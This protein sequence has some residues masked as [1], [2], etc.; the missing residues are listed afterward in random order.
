MKRTDDERIGILR[1]RCIDRKGMVSNAERPIRRKRMWQGITISAAKSLRASERVASWQIRC[2]LRTRDILAE[3]KFEIDDLELLAGRI[4]PQAASDSEFEDADA[5]VARY[6][7]T[8]GQSGHCELDLPTLFTLGVNGL[9]DRIDGLMADADDKRTE[10]YQSF[11][12]ALDGFSAMAE[13]AAATAEAGIASAPDWRKA[14]LR[15]IAESCRRIAH[16]PP[17]N[18]RDAVQLLW[19]AQLGAMLGDSAGLVVSGHIDRTLRP[20]YQADTAAGKISREQA[21]ILIESLYLLVNE[22]IADGLAMS[23]MVGGRDANGDDVTNDLSYLG[24]EALRRTKLIYPA[25]GVCWHEGTPSDL[26]DLAIELIGHGYSTPAFFGAETI[27]R[28]LKELGAA[29]EHACNYINSTCVEIT[30][31]A[32]SNVWVASPYFN[33]CGA[34]ME[35]IDAQ[36]DSGPVDNFEDFVAAYHRRM[37]DRIARAVAEQNNARRLRQ[38]F[39]G[40]PFQSVLTRDCIARGR[41]IDDG[42][43]IYNWVECSFVGLA[44]LADSLLVIEEEVFKQKNFTLSELKAM[45]DSDFAGNEATRLRFLHNYPKYGNACADVDHFLADTVGTLVKECG[46][47]KM[48]PDGSSFVPGCFC[49]VMHERLGRQTRATPDGRRA[50]FAFADG[51]GGAQGREM[52]G[53]TAAILSSTSWDHSPMIGGLAYNMKFNTS[54]FSSPESFERLRDLVITYLRRGGFETQ[55][56]VTDLE[57]LKRAREKPEEYRD[58]AVRIGGYVDYFTRLSPE[59]QQEVM[60]RTEFGRE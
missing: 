40:K 6:L 32:A 3:I 16:Q 57:T 24:L 19:L 45:L 12:P 56:N 51:G 55:I 5:Y 38:R 31:V 41:D 15:E 52:L 14:E 18:T 22:L 54:L 35:E 28:G 37:A 60:L 42:G 48:L 53:P 46:R 59:M 17:A 49:W 34:L 25:V 29:P 23:V 27:Q 36:V 30:P 1:Q 50:G 26:T 11:L 20:S 10:V 33:L 44:N 2:G 8:P 43:A 4:H 58:L 39:G 13:N 7:R 21:L 9:R 47:H